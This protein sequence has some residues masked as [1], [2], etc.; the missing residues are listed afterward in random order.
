MLRKRRGQNLYG[1]VA[2]ELGVA[3][4]IYLAHPSRANRRNDLVRSEALANGEWHGV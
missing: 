2:V 3:G 1:N 4:A